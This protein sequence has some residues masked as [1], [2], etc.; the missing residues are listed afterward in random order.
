MPAGLVIPLIEGGHVHRLRVR[1]PNPGGGPRYVIIPGSGTAPLT[2][3]TGT[4]WIIVESELDAFL[5]LQEGGDVAG[6]IAM[7]S[8][9]IFLL[10]LLLPCNIVFEF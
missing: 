4:A 8:A 5:L 10:N 3:G 7:G 1:R 6:I 2:L 9:P